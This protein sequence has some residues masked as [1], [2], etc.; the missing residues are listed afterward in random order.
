MGQYKVK[1]VYLMAKLVAGNP[2]YHKT[3][4]GEALMEL[5]HLG[6]IPDGRPSERSHVLDENHL[7]L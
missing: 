5:V 7:S 3:L 2:Q 6:V 1:C 4:R